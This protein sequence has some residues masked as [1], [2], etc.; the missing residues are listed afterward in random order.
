M[1]EAR[2]FTPTGHHPWSKELIFVVFI[3]TGD[4]DHF[5]FAKVFASLEDAFE[6]VLADYGRQRISAP[7]LPLLGWEFSDFGTM[8]LAPG[9]STAELWELV[10]W[11]GRVDGYGWYQ[12]KGIELALGPMILEY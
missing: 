5:H 2:T 3:R 11:E 7:E 1:V 12:I 10:T 6:S 4:D 9:S 8:W